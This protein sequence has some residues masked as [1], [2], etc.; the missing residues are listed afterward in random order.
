[1]M[2]HRTKRFKL[3]AETNLEA[4]VPEDNFYRQLENRLELSFV[5]ELVKDCYGEMGRPSIDPVVFFKLHLI[6]FFE[7]ISSERRLIEMAQLNLAHRWYLG[8]DLDEPLPDHS[9]MSKIRTRYG[10]EA[11]QRFFERIVELCIEAG[12]VDGEELYLDATDVDANASRQSLHSRFSLIATREHVDKVFTE[13]P[14]SADSEA[15][16]G[17]EVEAEPSSSSS[18]KSQTGF[19]SLVETH[20]HNRRSPLK[21]SHYIRVSDY[22]YSSSDPDARLMTTASG[23][24]SRLGYHDHYVVDGGKGRVIL[25]ALVTPG[26]VMENT[27]M[28]D[29]VRG[30]RFRWKLRPRQVTGD[31]KYGTTEN[32]KGLEDDGIS[33]YV[34]LPNFSKRTTYF[35]TDAFTYDAT[36]DRYICPQGQ[37]LA[38]NTRSNTE[39][40]VIY[41]AKG[42]ICNSCPTKGQCTTSTKGRQVSR[43]FH[44]DYVDKVKGYRLSSAYKRAIRKRKVWMEPLFAEAKVLHGLR[45]FS[46]EGTSQ[47]EHGRVDG[48]SW[49]E[50]QA[51]IETWGSAGLAHH[52]LP[53]ICP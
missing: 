32:I 25:S 1:M 27:P 7:G 21:R 47:G 28:L 48:R 4:L 17:G 26:S 33:A 23:G 22:R 30:V 52:P 3:F 44:Q 31:T 51:P 8:Y 10:L 24:R 50:P 40:A 16:P 13:N 49:A 45:R 19:V 36:N 18:Q 39:S 53:C 20:R 42:A 9:S 43:S 11:F 15:A 37:E 5:R 29:L 46:L 6:A 35:P 2:G 12:L 41:R 14:A 38:F 34:S